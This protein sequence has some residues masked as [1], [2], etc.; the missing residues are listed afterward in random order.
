MIFDSRE[1]S[2][3]TVG[4]TRVETGVEHQ[5]YYF[6]MAGTLIVYH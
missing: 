6:L 2:V 4:V 5:D 1:H 3:I